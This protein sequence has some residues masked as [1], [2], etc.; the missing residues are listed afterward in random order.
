MRATLGLPAPEE[1]IGEAAH[2]FTCLLNA[3]RVTLTRAAKVDGAP[4]VPSRWLLR[5]EALRKG[6]Q[7]PHAAEPWTQWARAR[8]AVPSVIKSVAAPAPRPDVSLRPRK[9]SVTAVEKWFANPYALY[10]QRILRLEPL[11]QI[12]LEPNAALRG[13]IVHDA[14]GRFAKKW[15]EA[16]PNDVAA[17]LIGLAREML[18]EL[19][20]SPRVAA[21]WAPRLGRFATW[22]A[23]TEPERRKGMQRQHAEIDGSMVL[24]VAGQPFTL[25]ARADRI[26]AR[27]HGERQS[28][29]ITDYKSAAGIKALATR[30]EK[31]LAPQLPLEAAI[32][33]AGGFTGLGSASAPPL[34]EALRYISAS[35]GEPPGQEVAIEIDDVAL[36]A[37]DLLRGL[38][39]MIGEFD[40]PETPYAAVRRAR[41][42]YDY[43][44]YAHLARV[45][46]WSG[47]QMAEDEP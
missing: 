33:L 4:T 42:T 15:P 31:G 12:G 37:R 25:T 27:A 28:L 20:A 1:R 5:L 35:G 13:E 22:F 46:E 16:L 23:E 38:E 6:L 3:P 7:V 10:A 36:H 14:L 43:D 26:D 34:V 8:N 32:A 9:L 44:D 11:P 39:A 29:T 21:F 40:R 19:S 17:E 24:G 47:E 45:A 2:D 30:A 18:E 41:Y